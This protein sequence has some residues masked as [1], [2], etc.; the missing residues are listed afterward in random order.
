MKRAYKSWLAAVLVLLSLASGLAGGAPQAEA[1]DKDVAQRILRA[2]VKLLTPFDADEDAG[3]LCSGSMLDEEGY[4]LTNFHCIG[5]PTSGPADEDL[6]SLGLAPGDLFNEKGLSVVALTDDPR[7]LPKPAYVAQALSW[8]SDLDI[9]VLKIVAN[10]NSRQKIAD[11]LPVVTMP[12]ADSDAVQTLDD[13]VVVGYPGIAGDTVTATEGRI[14]GFLDEDGDDEFDWFKTDVLVNQGNSG[15]SAL[16]EQGQLVG[17]PTARLQDRSGNV[18]YLIRPVNRAVPYIEEARRVGASG[19]QVGN[20]PKNPSNPPVR[21]GG[22][23]SFG[24]IVFGAGFDDN[25]GV[26]GEAEVFPTGIKEVHAGLPYESMR[27]GTAWGYSWQYEGQDVT[28]EPELEWEFGESGVLDLSLS[29]RRGLTDGEYNLQV[30]L[31][32]DLVQEAGFTVGRQPGNNRPPRKPSAGDDG[33]TI[34]GTIIDYATK[35]PINNAVIAVLFAGQTVDDFDADR[36]ENKEDTVVAFGVTGADGAFVLNRPLE[37]GEIYSV[38][39]GAK[40]YQRIAEDDAL[41][42]LDDDPEMLELDPIE[43]DRQ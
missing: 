24:G 21:P 31:R 11:T 38:V 26:T 3:S 2:S 1:V 34:V 19:G 32:G 9:A 25:S 10:Y 37:R 18:I 14:S 5:Y 29:G 35:R 22:R 17:I 15:G 36:T 23:G 41:E 12:M 40:G 8:D 27:D 28:G 43:M 4:I 6:E 39:V 16:N 7:R 33:V 13:V 42:I 30:F 20:P